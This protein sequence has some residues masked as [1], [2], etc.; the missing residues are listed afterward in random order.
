MQAVNLIPQEER[1]GGGAGLGGRSGGMVYVV[2]GGLAAVAGML[3]LWASASA[4]LSGK[5]GELAQ[6]QQQTQA[7]R[8]RTAGAQAP[9]DLAARRA[10]ATETLRGLLARRRD[11]AATLDAIGRTLPAD[12][13]LSAL[14]TAAA[15]AA[16]ATPGAPAAPAGTGLQ[17]TGCAPTQRAVARVIPRL[18]AVAGVTAVSLGSSTLAKAAGEGADACAGAT[19]QLTMALR[20]PAPPAAVSAPPAT[21]APAPPA[22]GA[23]ASAAPPA[24]APSAPPPGAASTVVPGTPSGSSAP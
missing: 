9:A 23:P 6:L 24:P 21:G 19:F 11:W 1:R 8:A 15:P 5:R 14:E 10:R 4:G 3:A 12:V 22:T 18:R 16:T 20:A 17:L 2:L 7:V 13:T